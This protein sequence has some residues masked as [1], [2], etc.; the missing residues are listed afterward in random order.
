VDEEIIEDIKKKVE[1][2]KKAVEELDEP[3]KSKGFETVLSKLLDQKPKI[4]PVIRTQPEKKLSNL[5]MIISTLDRTRYPEIYKFEKNLDR[6]LFVL[7]IAQDELGVDGLTP[8]QIADIL[9]NKFRI[10]CTA[11]AV[12]MALSDAKLMVDRERIKS[13][14]GGRAYKYRLMHGGYEYIENILKK[15]SKHHGD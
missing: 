13:S 8:P 15:H 9:T 1:I 4:G 11:P 2:A 14:S 12:S 3:L 6:A 5:D 7:K 10:N